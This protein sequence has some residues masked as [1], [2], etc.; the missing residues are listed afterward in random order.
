[1]FAPVSAS[2]PPASDASDG[3][4]PFSVPPKARAS[5][6]PSWALS[7]PRF[8][9]TG[10]VFDVSSPGNGF[11]PVAGGL[12][13]STGVCAAGPPAVGEASALGNGFVGDALALGVPVDPVPSCV[14]AG[15]AGF[16]PVGGVAEPSVPGAG[17][18]VPGFPGAGSSVPG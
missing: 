12:A 13:G 8:G 10:P 11:V 15:F 5:M 1:M 3:A 9:C 17:F 14:G 16:V 18:S 7:T 6:S 2:S 4:A